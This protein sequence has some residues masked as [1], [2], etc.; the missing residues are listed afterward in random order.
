MQKELKKLDGEDYLVVSN[1]IIIPIAY[2]API[3]YY[4]IFLKYNCKIDC[5]E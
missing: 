4:A 3:E 2:F 1:N 5:K